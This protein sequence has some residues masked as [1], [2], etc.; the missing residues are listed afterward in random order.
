MVNKNKPQSGKFEDR[1]G[2]GSGAI[3][4]GLGL[5]DWCGTGMTRNTFGIECPSVFRFLNVPLVANV[6]IIKQNN[7]VTCNA[8][9]YKNT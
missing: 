4:F 8:S 9:K 5:V 1:F 7:F 6:T 3:W 2:L